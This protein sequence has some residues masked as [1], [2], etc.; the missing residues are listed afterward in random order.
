MGEATREWSVGRGLHSPL[1]GTL[2]PHCKLV[3]RRGYVP[4]PQRK[5]FEFSS[6]KRRVLSI[7]I[8]KTISGQNREGFIDPVGAEDVKRRVGLKI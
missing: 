8:A 1:E 7:F 3:W 2:P 5:L 6:K 4:H